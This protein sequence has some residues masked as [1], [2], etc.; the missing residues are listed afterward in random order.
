MSPAPPESSR[1]RWLQR[2]LILAAVPGV[3]V[4]FASRAEAHAYLVSSSPRAGAR[5][6]TAPGAVV[7]KFSEA[8]Q[9]NLSRV[10]VASPD[11]GMA[12]GSTNGVVITVTLATSAPGMYRV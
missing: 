12:S 5:L 9:T 11:G 3:I 7:L 6:G 2:G 8:L 4:C 1:L 10:T